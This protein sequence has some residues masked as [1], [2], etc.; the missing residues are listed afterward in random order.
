VRLVKG[1]QFIHAASSLY[2]THQALGVHLAAAAA[3]AFRSY[4]ARSGPCRAAAAAVRVCSAYCWPW[5]FTNS[6]LQHALTAVAGG[7]IR[8]TDKQLLQQL[9]R[10]TFMLLLLLLL[11]LLQPLVW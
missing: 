9:V 1:A 10:L 6:L 2:G 7:R 5:L 3:V 8:G 4:F 11:L